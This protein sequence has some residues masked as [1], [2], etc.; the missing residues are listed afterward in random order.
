MAANALDELVQQNRIHG[1]MMMRGE[2]LVIEL[3]DATVATMHEA[4]V[5]ALAA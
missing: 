3:D 5:K 2:E 1:K 4:V